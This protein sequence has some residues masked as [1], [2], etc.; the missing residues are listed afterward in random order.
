M[1]VVGCRRLLTCNPIP[2]VP[3]HQRCLFSWKNANICPSSCTQGGKAFSFSGSSASCSA[4]WAPGGA[5]AW[6]PEQPARPAEAASVISAAVPLGLVSLLFRCK[7]LAQLPG[8]AFQGSC[9]KGED[10]PIR[11]EQQKQKAKGAGASS[12]PQRVSGGS[13]RALGAW[14]TRE[15][16]CQPAWCGRSVAGVCFGRGPALS[17]P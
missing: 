2:Y 11:L 10:F 5:G 4:S 8:A 9:R 1:D 12:A 7:H 15:A 17:S 3:K 6:L 13:T 14:P 16:A